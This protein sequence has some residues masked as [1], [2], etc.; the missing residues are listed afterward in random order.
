MGNTVIGKHSVI[1]RCILDEGVRVGE[2][3]YV[4]YGESLIPDDG[5]ITVLGKDAMV[6]AGTAIGRNCKVLPDVIPTDFAGRVV[7]AGSVVLQR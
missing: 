7:A 2:F 1:E 5:D 3:C 6:P 4:G